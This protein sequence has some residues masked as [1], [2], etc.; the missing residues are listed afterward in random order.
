M[1]LF[2]WFLIFYFLFLFLC[3][4]EM[5]PLLRY[6]F[7]V[8]AIV[9]DMKDWKWRKWQEKASWRRRWDRGSRMRRD[10]IDISLICHWYFTHVKRSL[11]FTRC[12]ESFYSGRVHS[13]MVRGDI[14]FYVKGLPFTVCE[15]IV[16][17]WQSPAPGV[18]RSL[19]KEEDFLSPCVRESLYSGRVRHTRCG[20]ISLERRGLPFTRCEEILLFWQSSPTLGVEDSLSN[21]KDFLSSGVRNH[22]IRTEF[23]HAEW[24]WF[25]WKNEPSFHMMKRNLSISQSRQ[26]TYI[27]HLFYTIIKYKKWSIRSYFI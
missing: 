8:S 15:E 11:L 23:L 25:F 16:L 6:L 7:A 13:H 4:V 12:E 21:E 5:L 19:Q 24:V 26:R 3:L 27:I 20:G 1:F 10:F 17:F 14:S 2:F 18:E 9:R 22:S